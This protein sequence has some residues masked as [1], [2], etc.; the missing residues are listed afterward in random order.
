VCGLGGR[1]LEGPLTGPQY[2]PG[3]GRPTVNRRNGSKTHQNLRR[4]RRRR[5]REPRSGGAERGEAR[6]YLAPRSPMAAHPATASAPSRCLSGARPR[7]ADHR[8]PSSLAVA[9]PPAGLRPC[10]SRALRVRAEVSARPDCR[11]RSFNFEAP[12]VV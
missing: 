10:G 7:C 8:S 2:L 4:R 11:F 6:T 3:T 1:K 12:N 5:R 9:A